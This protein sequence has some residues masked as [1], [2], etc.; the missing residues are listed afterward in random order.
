MPRK[1]KEV[2][3]Y[4]GGPLPAFDYA[5][6]R[7]E[8]LLGRMITSA[9][10]QAGLSQQALSQRLRLHGVESRVPAISRWENGTNIPNAYQIL[11]VSESLQIPNLLSCFRDQARSDA[12]H[13]LE[14]APDG[15][16]APQDP[17]F[18]HTVLF[19]VADLPASAGPGEYLT[20]ADFEL[21]EFPA[22]AIPERADFAVRVSG[23]SMEPVYQN[24]QLV[25]V[26][27]CTMLNP[28]EVGLFVLDGEGLI[29]RYDPRRPPAAQVDEYTDSEGLLY[30]QIVLTSFNRSYAPRIIPLSAD[31]RICGRILS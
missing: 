31:L 12:L 13:A 8:N 16:D 5:G 14:S 20:D 27:R 3:S 6:A 1:K 18:L 29:K 11:A 4:P 25:F 19:P 21:Q 24:G 23:D 10:H 15:A 28:G 22:S 30:P 2:P 9:R 7:Q 26:E 17:G